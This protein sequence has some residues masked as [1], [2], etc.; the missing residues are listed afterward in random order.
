MHPG[1]LGSLLSH[2][3]ERCTGFLAVKAAEQPRLEQF[4]ERTLLDSAVVLDRPVPFT[5]KMKTAK[6]GIL[7]CDLKRPVCWIFLRQDTPG[8][9]T[10]LPGQRHVAHR[11]QRPKFFLDF[12]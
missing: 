6:D 7:Q 12:G 5:P 1:R 9:Y 3:F 2:P 11:W 10:F 4:T 8:S